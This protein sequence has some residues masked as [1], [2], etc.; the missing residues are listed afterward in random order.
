MLSADTLSALEELPTPLLTVY[1]NTQSTAP[2]AHGPSAG[3][4]IWLKQEAKRLVENIPPRDQD[5]FRQQ[6]AETEGFLRDRKPKEKALVILAGSA[7]WELV[8]LRV[9]VENELHWGKPALAQLLWILSENKSYCLVIVDRKGARFLHFELGEMR[10]VSDQKFEVDISQWKKKDLGHVVGQRVNK[11]R[12]SQRDTYVHRMDAQYRR[13]CRETA[14]QA[15]RF[16]EANNCHGIFLVG[17][18][19]LTKPV[20]A[21]FS[22][23]FSL[24]VVLIA[25]DFG[26]L[27]LPELQDRLRPKIAEWQDEW[28]SALVARLFGEQR[29]AVIGID[30]TLAQLQKGKV[31]TVVLAHELKGNLRECIE[32]GWTD[33]SADPV[34]PACRR[35]RRAVELRDVLLNVARTT[36]TRI[37]VVRG[38]AADRLNQ[39]GGMAGWLR[40]R[41]Q[42][43]L[44]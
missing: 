36:N 20:H 26:N 10:E 27:S 22:K 17:S 24:P 6:I 29:K 42:G 19:E 11:T 31:R 28:E 30:E 9:Q 33:R 5:T 2:S 25:E 34:C 44:R 23:E 12:G 43:E 8:S 15:T 21:G 32:C 1:V 35:E 40:G 14:A 4:L 37:E 3:N 7:T 41:T 13:L 39:S 18:D 38:G 16:C